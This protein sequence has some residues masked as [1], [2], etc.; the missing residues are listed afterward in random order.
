MKTPH[1]LIEPARILLPD[2]RVDLSR[3]AVLACDQFTSQPDYWQRVEEIVGTAPSCLDLILPEVWLDQPDV[4]G[5]N[6]FDSPRDGRRATRGA[7]P[8]RSRISLSAPHHRERGAGGAGRR[9][10]IS[11]STV[12]LPARLH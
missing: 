3:W 7:D 12:M 10:G 6:R 1:R 5:A 9:S 8:S 4:G 2:E 11:S